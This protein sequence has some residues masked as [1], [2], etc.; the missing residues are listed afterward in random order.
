MALTPIEK[1][2]LEALHDAQ[3]HLDY[4]NYGDNWERECA[5]EA[6]LP[7]KIEAAIAA[8]QAKAEEK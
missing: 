8:A 7:E 3:D 4:C 5:R 1:M 6:K 2:L